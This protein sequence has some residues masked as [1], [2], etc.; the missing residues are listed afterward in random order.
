MG[1][2]VLIGL[3][4]AG[5]AF[6]AG[7]SG[8]D[9]IP[10]ASSSAGGAA[11][12]GGEQVDGSGDAGLGGPGASVPPGSA[13]AKAPVTG[14][15]PVDQAAWKAQVDA[16]KALAVDPVP[17]GVGNLPEFRADCQY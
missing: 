11:S 5:L 13:A 1:K 2:R 7:C 14:W 10:D 6:T 3:L 15:V 12:G 4:A 16:Y 8:D 17:A 9:S